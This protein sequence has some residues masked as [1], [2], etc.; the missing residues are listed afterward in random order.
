MLKW[1]DEDDE[2]WFK[3]FFAYVAMRTQFESTSPYNIF[4]LYNTIKTPT[5]AYGPFDNLTNLFSTSWETI[6]KIIAGEDLT[7]D[8]VERGAYEGKSQLFKSIMKVTPLK[9]IYEQ[10]FGIDD[11]IRYYQN[12]IMKEEFEELE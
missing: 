5:P 3:K 1:A 8:E 4:D 9:N 2:N 10:L 12:Q 11:K 6:R 7:E